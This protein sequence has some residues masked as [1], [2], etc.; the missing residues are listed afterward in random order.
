[1]KTDCFVRNDPFY[2][3]QPALCQLHIVAKITDSGSP[4]S[5]QPVSGVVDFLDFAG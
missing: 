4:A 5:E 3:F 2:S 1:M